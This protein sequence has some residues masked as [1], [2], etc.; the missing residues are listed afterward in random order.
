MY[1]SISTANVSNISA[2]GD[3]SVLKRGVGNKENSLN[4]NTDILII[5]M[6]IETLNLAV[7]TA[8]ISNISGSSAAKDM[9]VLKR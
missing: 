8:N 1:V 6:S 5:K 9:S 2:A 4:I 3:K 7:S